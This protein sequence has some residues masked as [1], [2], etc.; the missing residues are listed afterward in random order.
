M[1]SRAQV[2]ENVQP[3]AERVKAQ[4]ASLDTNK[5]FEKARFPR[6]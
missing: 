6:I 1:I 2:V 4:A 3:M 5:V